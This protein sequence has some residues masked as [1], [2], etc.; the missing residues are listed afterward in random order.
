MQKNEMYKIL[1][2][3]NGSANLDQKIREFQADHRMENKRKQKDKYTFT[4]C[5]RA[6][7]AVEQ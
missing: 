7:E 4:S 1:S 3:R 6:E 5:L 2:E